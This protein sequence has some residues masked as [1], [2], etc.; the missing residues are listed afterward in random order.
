MFLRWSL[1][2][3]ISN[4]N[5]IWISHELR[6][7]DT[8]KFPLPHILQNHRAL[9]RDLCVPWNFLLIFKISRE[10]MDLAPQLF[11][12][13]K[14]RFW[15]LKI[16]NITTFSLNSLNL[17]YISTSHD[18]ALASVNRTSVPVVLSLFRFIDQ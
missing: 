10:T 8:L 2:F 15:G 4:Y 17:C 13:Q 11:V 6:T 18:A 5:S 14:L 7:T 16:T 12:R 3:R 9:A 1:T